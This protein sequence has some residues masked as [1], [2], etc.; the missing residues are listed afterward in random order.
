MRFKS[1][2]WKLDA[3]RALSLLRAGSVLVVLL[4]SVAVWGQS[5]GL[6]SWTNGQTLNA[7]ELNANFS[8]LDARI[9]SV[10]NAP[11][12]PATAADAE[13]LPA[14]LF[15]IV[16]GDACTV[17]GPSESAY[18]ADCTCAADEVAISGGGYCGP[19]NAL[20][21]NANIAVN[22]VRLNP[23]WRIQCANA[24]PGNFYAL[25]LKVSR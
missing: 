19:N 22:G 15:H 17:A 7:S 20:I 5:S 13:A 18:Y 12:P 25:C 2:L 21:E 10:M 14:R 3:R 9:T 23:I 4:T 11:R 1:M 8:H 24:N 6:I 16:Q